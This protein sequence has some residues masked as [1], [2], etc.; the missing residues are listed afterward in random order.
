MK[1]GN[2]K[3]RTS[4]FSNH[5]EA[6]SAES[7]GDFVHKMK[8]CLKELR[9]TRRWARP[10]QRRDWARSDSTLLFVL[11][12]AEELIRIFMAS[13]RTAQRNN[14]GKLRDHPNGGV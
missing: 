7:R 11:S 13:V 4:P 8:T 14:A 5:G 1:M 2:G 6:E 12:E 10:I 9:E 3:R